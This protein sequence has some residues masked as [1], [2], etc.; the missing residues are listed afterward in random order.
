MVYD[1]VLSNARSNFWRSGYTIYG[2]TCGMQC[3]DDQPA[4]KRWGTA[5]SRSGPS[6][7]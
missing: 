6:D 5:I 2:F 3:V 4:W 1:A 7:L